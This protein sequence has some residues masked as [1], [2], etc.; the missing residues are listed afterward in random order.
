M[1]SDPANTALT[2]YM[3]VMWLRWVNPGALESITVG[4]RWICFVRKERGVGIWQNNCLNFVSMFQ[5]QL[6]EIS[7]G[8]PAQTREMG[9]SVVPGQDRQKDSHLSRALQARQ[10]SQLYRELLE[11]R[12][13]LP[14]FQFKEEV[15]NSHNRGVFTY[16]FWSYQIEVV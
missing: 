15:W 3:Y 13:L 6:E 12:K 10:A 16:M 11:G 4:F 7:S 9:R 1:Q 2:A 8:S 5:G 14:V